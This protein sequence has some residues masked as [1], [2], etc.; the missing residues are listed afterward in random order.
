MVLL[1]PGRLHESYFEHLYLA[2]QLGFSA[3]EGSDPTVRDNTLY[4]KTL[5][6]LQRVHALLRRLDD[7]F[8]DPLELRTDSALGVAGLLEVVRP[9]AVLVA[10]RAVRSNAGP[11]GLPAGD[12]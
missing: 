8:C 7:G 2:R 12:Q 6:G 5:D 4:L 11:A 9:E 10:T 1:T 3:V